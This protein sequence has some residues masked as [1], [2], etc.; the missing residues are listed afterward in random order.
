[1]TDPRRYAPAA[2]RNRDPIV[3]VLRDVLPISG[4]VLELAS[5]TGEHAVYFAG[6][7]PD[8]L[9][10]P[11]DPDAAARASIAAWREDAGLSNLLPPLDID[12]CA[13]EWPVE[14]VQAM[15]CIN[16]VHIAPWSATEGLFGGAAA[17]LESGEPLVLYGPFRR[18][19]H[20][21]E[22][23][24]QSFDEDLQRRDARWGLRSVEDVRACALDAGI[25]FDQMVQMPAN[26]LTLVFRK[27]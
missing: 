8:I 3:S 24:N 15:V 14:R 12:V 27:R 21:L 17:L 20:P 6:A 7:F 23:S 18:E 5:G 10:I 16:M 22:P 19:G 11:S 2:S 4:T 9:W 25:V 13:L 1:M 26:N